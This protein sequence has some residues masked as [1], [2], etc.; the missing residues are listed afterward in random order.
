[1]FITPALTLTLFPAASYAYICVI[2]CPTSLLCSDILT[3][4]DA[5]FP[6]IVPSCHCKSSWPLYVVHVGNVTFVTPTLSLTLQD[7]VYPVI[8]TS[9]IVTLDIDGCAVSVGLLA[10]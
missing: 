9:E 3:L 4:Y 1:M 2:Y 6:L 8:S 10:L 5:V 7:T